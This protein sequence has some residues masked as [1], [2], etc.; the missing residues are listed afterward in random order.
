MLLILQMK[1]PKAQRG[2]LIGLKTHRE[3]VVELNSFPHL[4]I[5]NLVF[6]PLCHLPPS[7]TSLLSVFLIFLFWKTHNEKNYFPYSH[8][9]SSLRQSRAFFLTAS[10]IGEG[11]YQEKT[12]F[13]GSLLP[14]KPE[15]GPR[16]SR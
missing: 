12:N 1:K 13:T 8:I 15:R 2:D 14:C 11:S 7:H 10:K 6:F 5:S 16:S 3:L 9:L 4:L